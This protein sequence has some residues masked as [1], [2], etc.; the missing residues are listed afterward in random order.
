[1]LRMEDSASS[2]DDSDDVE[3]EPNLLAIAEMEEH[4]RQLRQEYETL[5]G[6]GP[7][8][9]QQPGRLRASEQHL[10]TPKPNYCKCGCY[11]NVNDM[12]VEEFR[13]QYI[14][15]D[16]LNNDGQRKGKFNQIRKDRYCKVQAM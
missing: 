2:S 6:R 1:M 4:D 5:I 15:L 7:E 12:D 8:P 11:A 3:N 16:G 9:P 13:A 10:G 14:A